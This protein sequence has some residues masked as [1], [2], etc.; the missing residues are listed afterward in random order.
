MSPSSLP[1]R[2]LADEPPVPRRR[3]A[4]DPLT[5]RAI[6]RVR[7]APPHERLLALAGCTLSEFATRIVPE[8]SRSRLRAVLE[9]AELRGRMTRE[10]AERLGGVVD[11]PA[12]DVLTLFGIDTPAVRGRPPRRSLPTLAGRRSA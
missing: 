1:S 3:P 6:A 4:I 11:A 2:T 9:Q 5:R 8:V 10:W 7:Q 12:D